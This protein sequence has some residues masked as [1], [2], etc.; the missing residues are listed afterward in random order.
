MG[1]LQ[2]SQYL[3]TFLGASVAVLQIVLQNDEYAQVALL[4][5]HK[6]IASALNNHFIVH[7]LHTSNVQFTSILI[8]SICVDER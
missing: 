1:R 6:N 3:S 4:G 8:S 7:K 2:G 5:G